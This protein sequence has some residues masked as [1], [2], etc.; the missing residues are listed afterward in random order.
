MELEPND[1]VSDSRNTN[2]DPNANSPLGGEGGASAPPPSVSNAKP[3]L[4]DKGAI[5]EG[6]FDLLKETVGE[7]YATAN[8]IKKFK[9][10]PDLAKSYV[11]LSK[12]YSKKM[13][14]NMVAA[15]TETSTPEEVEAFYNK[16]GRPETP[17]GYKMEAEVEQNLNPDMYS[18]FKGVAHKIGLTDK[19]FEELVNF[20]VSRAKEALEQSEINTIAQNQKVI[21]QLKEEFGSKYDYNISAAKK[22]LKNYK[23][24]DSVVSTIEKDP[25][26]V[27][28]IAKIGSDILGEA[29][30][31]GEMNNANAYEV[32]SEIQKLKSS[33]A[34]FDA[35]HPEHDAVVERVRQ[36]RK[37]IS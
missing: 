15:P 23:V 17:D 6:F 30:I 19:Q 27:G 20:E 34:Y 1:N 18:Q 22:L 21:S 26:L 9:G 2:G 3:I 12:A 28:L 25:S 8:E 29:D 13:P 24:P 35:R 16:I 31:K 37:A 7:E 32:Q 33:D 4:G 11:E 14:E 5:G 36:L 10:I